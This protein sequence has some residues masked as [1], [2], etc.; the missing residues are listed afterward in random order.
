MTSV[1]ELFDGT[2]GVRHE[3]VRWDVYDRNGNLAGELMVDRESAPTITNDTTRSIRRQVGTVEV[4]ARPRY[5]DDPTHVY[6]DDVDSLSMRVKPKW[7]LSTGDEFPM[8][9]F[10]WADDSSTLWSWGQPRQGSLT[11]LSVTLDQALDQNVGY[12][13]GTNIVGAI[14]SQADAA[15]FGPTRRIIDPSTAK[16][17]VPVAWAAG[18]DTRLTVITRLNELAGFLPPY[19]NNNGL[20]V[21]RAAPNLAV[22][23]PDFVYGLD[24][25]LVNGSIVY[26]NDILSAPNRYMVIGSN[27]DAEVVGIFDIPDVAPN[28]FLNTG[29]RRVRTIDMQGIETTAA[30]TQAAAAAYGSD[31]TTYSWV[32]FDTPPDPRHDTFDVVSVLGASYLQLS[33][34]LECRHGGRMSHTGRASYYG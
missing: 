29:V 33:W 30:A 10:V 18:R 5:D 11:D 15:G 32:N 24:G 4:L 17:G 25:V 2:I 7:V 16:L 27:P 13:T 9:E 21:C 34:S 6:A 14:T 20:L 31:A 1:D 28:S 22:T 23:T 8:G 26:S 19:L 3:S 12:D